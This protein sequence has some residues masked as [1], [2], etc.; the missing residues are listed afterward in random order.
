M[1]ARP[2]RAM[3]EAGGGMFL[4]YRPQWCDRALSD[5]GLKNVAVA[6]SLE[7]V[8][9][10][11]LGSSKRQAPQTQEPLNGRPSQGRCLGGGSGQKS[12][13]EAGSPGA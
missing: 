3:L 13:Q 6:G 12:G 9:S 8:N 11:S 10:A 1:A 2:I 5:F 7:A 4:S